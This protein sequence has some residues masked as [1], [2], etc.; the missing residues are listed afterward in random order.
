MAAAPSS[1]LF[2]TTPFLARDQ[3]TADVEAAN[4]RAAAA[5]DALIK[6]Y[7]APA[8]D[9]EEASSLFGSFFAVVADMP[10]LAQPDEAA[11]EVG[12]WLLTHSPT[13]QRLFFARYTFASR[14][15]AA[16]ACPPLIR[17]AN[18][19]I[20]GFRRD[21]DLIALK[22]QEGDLS[23]AEARQRKTAINAALDEWITHRNRLV[24]IAQRTRDERAPL[25]FSSLPVRALT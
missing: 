11:Q 16:I 10:C 21:R 18:V 22:Q 20:V 8:L 24:P 3:W 4:K 14:E 5:A 12:T 13:Y 17:R 2:P 9:S 7:P 23:S 15:F 25:L 1:S 19:N 6:A